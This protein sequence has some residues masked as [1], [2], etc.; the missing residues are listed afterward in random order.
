MRV[1]R[2]IVRGLCHHHGVATAVPDNRV[3]AQVL[4]PP[5]PELLENTELHH[6]EQDII[7]Y[8]YDDRDMAPG[9]QSIWFVRLFERWKFFAMVLPPETSAPT[10]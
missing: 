3:W 1:I 6:V 5:P 4:D 10:S 8:S 9:F 2:K 7:E